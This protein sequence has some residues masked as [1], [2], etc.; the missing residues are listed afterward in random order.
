MDIKCWTHLSAFDELWDE[1]PAVMVSYY[2]NGSGLTDCERLF[3]I[4][5]DL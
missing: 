4:P 1:S 2:P 5:E 3:L